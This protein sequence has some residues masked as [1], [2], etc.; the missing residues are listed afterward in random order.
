MLETDDS[1]P[2][3]SISESR[4]LKRDD[5]AH[6]SA[7]VL[8]RGPDP[9]GSRSPVGRV[10]APGRCAARRC[11]AG[12][13]CVRGPRPA[14]APEP[15]TRAARDTGRGGAAAVAAQAYAQLELPRARARG[16]R[17]PGVSA[18]HSGGSAEGPRREDPRQARPGARPEDH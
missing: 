15:H 7:A 1:T 6:E 4:D 11:R 3:P 13:D 10:D 9:G 5:R 2:T 17:E 14:L 12:A 18:V 8:R 16:A